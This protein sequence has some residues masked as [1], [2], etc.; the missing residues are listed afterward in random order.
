MGRTG[1]ALCFTWQCMYIETHHFIKLALA[2]P[3]NE[4]MVNSAERHFW[5]KME[6]MCSLT[7]NFLGRQMKKTEWGE[8]E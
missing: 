7:P 8:V 1:D 4:H 5:G 2:C 6:T 3:P